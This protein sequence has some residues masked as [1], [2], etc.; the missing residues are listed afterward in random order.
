MARK[1]KRISNEQLYSKLEQIER[2]L[3][4]EEGEFN[5]DEDA[6]LSELDKLERLEEEIKKDVSPHPLSRITYHDFTK[7]LIGAF[8]GVVGH[9]AFIYGHHIAEGLTI[10]R[11]TVLFIV[12]LLL[13]I[14][15]LYFSGFRR[16]KEYNKYLPL[17]VAVIY[18]TALLVA[19]AVLFL[20]GILHYPPH[21]DEIYTNLSAVSILAVMGAATADLIGGE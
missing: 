5:R 9:F 15:F 4:K 7:G 21:F 13:L 16:I 6:E 1:A 20:F 8:F 17:R 18:C 12:S 14:I 2:L 3:K 11:A 19:T 10:T